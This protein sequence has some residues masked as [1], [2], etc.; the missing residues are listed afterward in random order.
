MQVYRRESER[1]ECA[2]QT[3]T[4]QRRPGGDHDFK[5]P[6][7]EA[8]LAEHRDDFQS[9]HQDKAG[10]QRDGGT[11]ACFCQGDAGTEIQEP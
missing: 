4:E 6:D 3:E 2:A 9:A 5:H 7:A 1:Q 11:P 10:S 8:G